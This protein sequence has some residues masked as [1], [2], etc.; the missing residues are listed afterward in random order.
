[1]PA[2]FA[3]THAVPRIAAAAALL[4]CLSLL[5]ILAQ[6]PLQILVLFLIVLA[7]AVR[8]V[9]AIV[10]TVA[11]AP[12][13]RTAFASA[14]L[15][16]GATV[17][18]LVLAAAAGCLGRLAID[19][20]PAEDN[21][22]GVRV[23]AVVFTGVVAASLL[24]ELAAMRV[25]LSPELFWPALS[26]HVVTYATQGRTDLAGR[27]ASASAGFT[28]LEGL[29]LFLV[30]VTLPGGRVTGLLVVRMFAIGASAAA[31]PTLARLAGALVSSER[32]LTAL[33]DLVRSV[34]LSATFSDVNA[35]GSFF[36]LAT[37]AAGGLTVAAR[38][39]TRAGW[40][41]ATVLCA[42]ALWW[43]GSR[44]AF[45][46]GVLSLGI[47][48]LWQRGRAAR[49]A[50]AA[51]AVCALIGIW[52]FPNPIVD[53]SA[54]GALSIRAELARV[55]FRLL[56]QAPLF[57]IGIGTFYAQSGGE[58][59]DPMVRALYP[60]ENAHNNYLQV[61]AELGIVGLG[62]FLAV[63]LAVALVVYRSTDR[64][65]A[66]LAGVECGLIAFLITCLAGHPLL[67]PEVSVAFW[68]MLGAVAI[69]HAGGDS[70]MRFGA[71]AG[72]TALF[73]LAVS[74]PFRVSS[75]IQTLNLARI[76]YGLAD[77]EHDGADKFRRMTSSVTLF[78]PSDATAIELPYRLLRE[79]EPVTIDVMFAGRA[80][81]RL[82]AADT[83][84]RTYRTAVVQG[85]PD[86]RFLPLQLTVISGDASRV[87]LGQL[88]V[89]RAFVPPR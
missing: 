51:L 5:W 11:A 40:T 41:I 7:A 18:L 28:L 71:S 6:T 50:L 78:V 4:A 79:G 65:L 32:P 83:A 53:R 61:L 35:A 13:I 57:G 19:G 82:L 62:A 42:A 22:R 1:M 59:H 86:A 60:R 9:E 73:V 34:R 72:T 15:Y 17:E 44:A 10:F 76:A 74:V 88:V 46:A 77:W 25:L 2:G 8:P 63:L 55:A 27:F 3:H 16:G 49:R 12:V 64:R 87:G 89:R 14:G 26:D 69:A 30:V 48:L 52:M 31:A 21:L 23:A 37:L 47:W 66:T 58:I 54:V 68:S 39:R 24:V 85:R 29:L 56:G 36:V 70:P 45:L 43:S 38:G 33:G 75:E 84:W 80:A 67:N 20:P 81:D